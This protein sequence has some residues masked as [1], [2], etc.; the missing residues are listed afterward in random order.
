MVEDEENPIQPKLSYQTVRRNNNY[1]LLRSITNS[2]GCNK[3]EYAPFRPIA[4]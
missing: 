2:N 4:R 3:L 1:S